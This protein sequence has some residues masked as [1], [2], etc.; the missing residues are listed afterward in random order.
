MLDFGV[1][2]TVFGLI[3]L[4]ELPDK[5]AMAGL[6]LSTRYN[7]LWVF[8]GVAA[9]FAVHVAVAVAAGSVI[10]LLPERP[11][12]L[13]AAAMFA[14]AAVLLW[15]RSGAAD[16]ADE[17]GPT[18]V[19]STFPAVAG[20]SFAVVFV[21]EFGDLT[22]ILAANLAAKYDDPA[23]V[24][25]GAILALWAVALVAVFGGRTLVRLVPLEAIGRVAAAAMGVV[26]VATAWA[27]L[28]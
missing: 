7:P 19:R 23:S 24:A 5:T 15:R 17:G 21:A 12:E 11:V 16:E 25:V 6:V 22:Q 14:V 9:A 4:A 2:G 8:A 10:G 18:E 3:F 27:A 20:M 26:A 13:A 28:G 1:V